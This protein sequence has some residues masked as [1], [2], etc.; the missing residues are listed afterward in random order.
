MALR[1]GL[2]NCI[3]FVACHARVFSALGS[4]ASV[5]TRPVRIARIHCPRFVPRVGLPRK[6]FFDRQFDSGAKISQGS[7]K[8]RILDC[9]LGVCIYIYIYIYAYN[10][11]CICIHMYVHVY[12]FMCI[13]IYI[14][15]YYYYYYYI[16]YIYIYIYIYICI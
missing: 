14:Y 11:V 12:T 15:T 16:M 1:P 3:V 2:S 6:S 5:H 4:H 8:T 13:Y 10:Y 7:E 9:E